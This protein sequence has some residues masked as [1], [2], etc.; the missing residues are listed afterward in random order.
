[1]SIP[2]LTKALL[3]GAIVA[4]LQQP[5]A[6]QVTHDVNQNNNDFLPA[7]ITIGAGERVFMESS[8]KFR[9]D[10]MVAKLRDFGLNLRECFTDPEEL[11]AVLLLTRA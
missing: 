11:F 9:V 1:M 6:A 5:L 3:S 4:A 10:D 7:D 8:R 2:F